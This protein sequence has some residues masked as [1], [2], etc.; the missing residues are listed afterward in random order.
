MGGPQMPP[1]EPMMPGG[2]P[3]GGIDLM[4][5]LGAPGGPSTDPSALPMAASSALRQ[6]DQIS[7]MVQDLVRMFPGNE[8]AARQIMEGVERWKQA[9]VVSVAPPTSAMPGAGMML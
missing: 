7:T 8:D 2:N 5:L 3:G 4:S 1:T 6:F 9:V